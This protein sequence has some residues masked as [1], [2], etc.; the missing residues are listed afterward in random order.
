MCSDI[1]P[2]LSKMEIATVKPTYGFGIRF[3]F[4]K[5]QKLDIR[6]DFGFGKGTSG[7]YFSLNQAF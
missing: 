7:I 1:A 5:L 4:D 2:K 3:R 6:A